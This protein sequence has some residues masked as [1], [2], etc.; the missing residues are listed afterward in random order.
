MLAYQP[1]LEWLDG[2]RLRS[3]M[4]LLLLLPVSS[5][6]YRMG[7][8]SGVCSWFLGIGAPTLPNTLFYIKS[9]RLKVTQ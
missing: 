2:G 5:L 6:E 4:L 7:V 3:L 8:V 1:P 9:F